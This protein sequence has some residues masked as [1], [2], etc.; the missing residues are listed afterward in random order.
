MEDTSAQ[1]YLDEH[2]IEALLQAATARLLFERPEHPRAFLVD[3]LER[4]K[5]ARDT[6]SKPPA[7][8]C[9]LYWRQCCIGLLGSS[10]GVFV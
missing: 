6:Q 3:Y 4:V 2:K 8:R 10:A 1:A 7:V 5:A 9:V